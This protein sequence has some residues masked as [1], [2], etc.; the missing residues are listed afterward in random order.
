M[1]SLAFL[2]ER[3][4]PTTGV[5]IGHCGRSR[6]IR[7]RS[8]SR[9]DV[10]RQKVR[11]AP[12]MASWGRGEEVVMVTKA[13]RPATDEQAAEGSGLADQIAGAVLL[14]VEVARRVLPE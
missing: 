11:F 3:R 5:V 2:A 4:R 13:Q 14:P 1:R 8:R 6:V 12:S 10:I 7:N 9:R